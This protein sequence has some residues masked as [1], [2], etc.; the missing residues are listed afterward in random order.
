MS[1]HNSEKRMILVCCGTGCLANGGGAVYE[2]F[3]DA[4]T[5]KANFGVETFAKATGCNGLCEKGPLVKILPDDITYC[6]VI[7]PIS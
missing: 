7:A 1:N 5:G 6:R 2:A 3:C 4:L